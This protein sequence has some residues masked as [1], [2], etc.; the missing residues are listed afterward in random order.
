MALHLVKADQA[1]PPKPLTLSMG[2]GAGEIGSS[3]PELKF[4]TEKMRLGRPIE[5]SLGLHKLLGLADEEEL[6]KLKLSGEVTLALTLTLTLTLAASCS[7]SSSRERCA[8]WT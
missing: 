7:S 5:A 2:F 1:P 3:A 8:C 4:V 6:L